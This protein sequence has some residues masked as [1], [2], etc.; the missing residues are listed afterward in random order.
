MDCPSCGS[1]Q[2]PSNKYC[3]TCGTLVAPDDEPVNGTREAGP[4]QVPAMNDDH[5]LG[6]LYP[7]E[8]ALAATVKF[9]TERTPRFRLWH[10]V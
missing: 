7:A 9:H 5:K 10:L 2:G 3:E 4:S 1:Q 8:S 6:S